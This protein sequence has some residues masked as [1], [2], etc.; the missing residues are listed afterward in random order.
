LSYF[1]SLHSYPQACSPAELLSAG[2]MRCPKLTGR[3]LIRET[4]SSIF[5]RLI[6]FRRLNSCYAASTKSLYFL[7]H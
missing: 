7:D 4:G 5:N 3:S 6:Y 2:V 1:L